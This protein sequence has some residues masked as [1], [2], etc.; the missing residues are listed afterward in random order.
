MR[1]FALRGAALVACCAVLG[2]S[3]GTAPV[4]ALL[5]SLP[6][7]LTNTEV[8]LIQSSNAFTLALF[9]TASAAE[10]Q[11]NVFLSPLSAS[12]VLGMTLNGARNGTFDAM[13]SALQ[14][15]AQP[16]ADINTSYKSLISLLTGLDPTTEMRIANSV[17]YRNT[18]PINPAF[19]T[20]SH[21][22]FDAEVSALDFAKAAEAKQTINGW[23]SDKTAGRIPT[24]VD[25]IEPDQEMILINAI[26]FKG[27]WRTAF[28]RGATKM[29]SFTSGAGTVQ[30]VPMMHLDGKQDF[31]GSVWPDGTK[32]ADL[33]Y[34]NGAFV[35]SLYLPPDT[36]SIERFV[37][38][39]SVDDLMPDTHGLELKLSLPRVKLE[40][41]RRLNDDLGALGMGIAF[42]DAADFSG[43]TTNAHPLVLSE[44]LQKTF[45]S[46]DEEGTEA[47][48]VTKGVM[49]DSAPVSLVMRCDRPY[50]VIIRERLSGTIVFIG[51]INTI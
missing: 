28:D 16:Q 41:E 37:S 42:T 48:A 27:T 20:A 26:Y 13:R 35:M 44:V 29:E 17:W 39:L 23:V 33:P 6:R 19:V 45:L 4:P 9:Q 7:P 5:T 38:R 50:L 24:I 49:A 30:T 32:N 14:F 21:D 25:Q 51:K 2:C 31:R 22:Y 34:G 10:P 15:G 12:M 11:K 18:L 46:I 1:P 40:Y 8:A 43:M 36:S 47:A 3:D